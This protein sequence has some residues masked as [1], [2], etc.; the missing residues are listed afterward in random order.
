MRVGVDAHARNPD[1]VGHCG[2]LIHVRD[3]VDV[4]D[5]IDVLDLDSRIEDP[6]EFAADPLFSGRVHQILVHV[7]EQNPPGSVVPP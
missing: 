2:Y 4:L 3:L 5:L 1:S 7:R 6:G